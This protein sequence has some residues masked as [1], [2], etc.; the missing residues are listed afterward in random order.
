MLICDK[1]FGVGD[2]KVRDHCHETGKYRGSVHWSGNI[3]F[4]L[5]KNFPV[6]FDNLRGYDIHLIIKEI[7][8]FDAKVSVI[9]NGFKKY[10]AFTINENMVLIDSMQFMNSGLDVLVKNLSDNH[11]KYLSEKFSCEFLKLVKQKGLY[12]YKYMDNFEKF[13]EDKLPDKRDFSVL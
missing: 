12:L 10:I 6:I 13:S 11:F 8:T 7:G 3:H 2:D 1:I 5:T 4:K 9:P